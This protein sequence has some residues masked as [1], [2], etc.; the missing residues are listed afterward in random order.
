MSGVAFLLVFILDETIFTRN[1]Y[2]IPRGSYLARLTGAQQ[3]QAWCHRSFLQCVMRPIVAITKIPVLAVL[4]FYFLSFAWV[5]GVNT[6]IGIWLTN[7]YGFGTRGIG[8][9][10]PNP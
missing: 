10:P 4:I 2:Q 7:D 6:T 3:V 8:Q 5:I 1:G 9:P